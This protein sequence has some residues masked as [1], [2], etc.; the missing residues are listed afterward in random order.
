MNL[1]DNYEFGILQRVYVMRNATGKMEVLLALELIGIPLDMEQ[2][3]AFK[4]QQVRIPGRNVL[5]ESMSFFQG[6]PQDLQ[7]IGGH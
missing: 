1:S 6:D 5:G 3:S 7:G 4:D 2:D